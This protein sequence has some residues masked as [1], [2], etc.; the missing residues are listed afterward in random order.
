MP[1]PDAIGICANPAESLVDDAGHGPEAGMDFSK[2]LP[3]QIL[4][5]N[6]SFDASLCNGGTEQRLGLPQPVFGNS[7]ACEGNSSFDA[8][9]CGEVVVVVDK[10]DLLAHVPVT[11]KISDLSTKERS[12]VA[13]NKSTMRRRSKR[14]SICVKRAPNNSSFN[15]PSPATP[16]AHPTADTPKSSASSVQAQP[17]CPP[18]VRVGVTAHLPAY[19]VSCLPAILD[20]WHKS[21]R[22]ATPHLSAS[23]GPSLSCPM[24]VSP[25]DKGVAVCINSLNSFDHTRASL[26]SV[27]GVVRARIAFFAVNANA[28]AFDAVADVLCSEWKEVRSFSMAR[29]AHSL[30]LSQHEEMEYASRSVHILPR[31]LK[32]LTTHCNCLRYIALVNVGL[33]DEG[34]GRL[35]E[36][37]LCGVC[38]SRVRCLDLSRNMLGDASMG[39]M[40]DALNESQLEVL[41]LSANRVTGTGAWTLAQGTRELEVLHWIDLRQNRV[42]DTVRAQVAS[43]AKGKT[44][45]SSATLCIHNLFFDPHQ[46]FFCVSAVAKRVLEFSGEPTVLPRR[47]RM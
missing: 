20:T 24:E 9:G 39:W 5:S 45:Q 27:G 25:L 47:V 3:P 43:E 35:V 2:V 10:R 8:A 1:A 21:V 7:F 22:G 15:R 44:L 42:P 14:P 34:S 16:V 6:F 19:V 38:R 37:F 30:L 33:M 36:Q 23:P 11:E 4:S 26:A 40:C 46:P 41:L 32:C 28:A 12:H 17:L 18:K 31:L 29:H 13:T